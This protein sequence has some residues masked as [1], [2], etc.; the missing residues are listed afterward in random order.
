MENAYFDSML[1]PMQKGDILGD[2]EILSTTV[3]AGGFG[4]IYRAHRIGDILRKKYAVKE[5]CINNDGFAITRHTMG[6]FTRIHAQ[7]IAGVLRAKFK[8]E[9]KILYTISR[10]LKGRHCK[11]PAIKGL[12]KEENGRLYY[13]MEYVEGP[14]LREEID[15]WGVIPEELALRYITTVGDALEQA[16]RWG[17]VHCDISPNNIIIC[18]PRPVLVDFGNA[19]SFNHELTL[20]SVRQD[21]NQMFLAYQAAVEEAE[22][23]IGEVPAE[24]IEA[25]ESTGTSGFQP[26]RHSLIGTT[27]GDVYSLAATLY[28][29]LTGES[30]RQCA[31]S[32]EEELRRA[33]VT[34]ETATAVL[35]VLN[36][37]EG[38]TLH[39]FLQSLAPRNVDKPNKK[40]ANI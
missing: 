29:I 32:F 23:G 33:N 39:D 6:K 10:C 26:P 4:R 17:M 27:A 3:N 40:D 22:E 25:I 20:K 21:H 34:E 7:G 37:P 35:R 12:S 31:T 14:T 1:P 24:L 15:N 8:Q 11:V 30:I 16:H 19:R 28:Y 2:Y 36:D 5:F 38:I 18:G 13:V 9:A